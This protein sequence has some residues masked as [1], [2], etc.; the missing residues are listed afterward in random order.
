[1]KIQKKKLL[2]FIPEIV[3]RVPLPSRIVDLGIDEL[4]IQL[5][6]EH[7]TVTLQSKRCVRVKRR[8]KS[9]VR[10]KRSKVVFLSTPSSSTRDFFEKWAE[11]GKVNDL[12]L[13]GGW[14]GIDIFPEDSSS[15]PL[16]GDKADMSK[17][18]Q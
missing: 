2:K 5:G 1:M 8:G 16:A 7:E 17:Q 3:L 11:M 18:S 4:G 12:S 9:T 10:A 14:T 13:G 15:G 6:Q